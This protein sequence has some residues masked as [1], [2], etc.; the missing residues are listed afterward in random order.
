MA[1]E[2]EFE[3]LE[4]DE[5]LEAE[6]WDVSQKELADTFENA[7]EKDEIGHGTTLKRTIEYRPAD[8][9][10]TQF[11]MSVWREVVKNELNGG[12]SIQQAISGANAAASAFRDRFAGKGPK[13]I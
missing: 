7:A 9:Y 3:E 2:D 1:I 10:A 13:A 8:E 5:S 6:F 11:E 4:M 12:A